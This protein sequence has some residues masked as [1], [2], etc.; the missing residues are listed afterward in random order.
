MK[1]VRTVCI[2]CMFIFAAIMLTLVLRTVSLIYIHN[3]HPKGASPWIMFR[4]GLRMALIIAP[5][6]TLILLLAALSCT[7]RHTDKRWRYVVFATIV[8]YFLDLF[9]RPIMVWTG[10]DTT[11]FFCMVIVFVPVAMLVSLVALFSR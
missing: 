6:Q 2:Y 7:R 8:L 3:L 5:V 4:G 11:I 9:I 1:P 10:D